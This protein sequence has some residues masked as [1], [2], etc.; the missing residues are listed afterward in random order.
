MSQSNK[1]LDNT[2][3]KIRHQARKMDFNDYKK[4]LI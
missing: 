2:R 4:N 1:S 3:K